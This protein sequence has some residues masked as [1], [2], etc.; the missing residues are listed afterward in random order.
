MTGKAKQIR[1]TQ[2]MIDAVFSNDQCRRKFTHPY[3]DKSICEMRLTGAI[4]T[5]VGKEYGVS[6]YYCIQCVR[7]VARLY[8]MFIEGEQT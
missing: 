3:K 8:T 2:Q 1:I 4:Y 5:D 7:K 6:Q